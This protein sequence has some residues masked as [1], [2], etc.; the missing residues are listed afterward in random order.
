VIPD[1]VITR[2]PFSLKY[3]T[4]SYELRPF[5]FPFTRQIVRRAPLPI[6]PRSCQLLDTGALHTAT[7][8]RFAGRPCFCGV[9]LYVV[10]TGGVTPDLACYTPGSGEHGPGAAPGGVASK[11]GWV[12]MRVQGGFNFLWSVSLCVCVCVCALKWRF[13]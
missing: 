1:F 3:G 13:L 5:S 7:P 12:Y 11:N 6:I 10:Y 8:A 9:L 2:L 4:W